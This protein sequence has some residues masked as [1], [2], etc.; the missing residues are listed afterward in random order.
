MWFMHMNGYYRL[1]IYLYINCFDTGQEVIR[2][3]KTEIPHA[4]THAGMQIS[5]F[6]FTIP[7]GTCKEAEAYRAGSHY[8][9]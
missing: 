8:L 1:Y 7:P 4:C 3:Y 6:Y 5:F 9:H 2:Y